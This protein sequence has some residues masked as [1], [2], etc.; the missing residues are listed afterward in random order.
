[1]PAFYV[2]YAA[3]HLYSVFTLCVNEQ[4]WRIG[5]R[6]LRCKCGVTYSSEGWTWTGSCVATLPSHS[7][8]QV[9]ASECRDFSFD[10]C[11]VTAL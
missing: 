6:P 2:N 8:T 11:I 4:C 5:E 9:R 7:V 10:T 1:M 3:V